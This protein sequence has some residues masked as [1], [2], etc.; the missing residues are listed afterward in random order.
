MSDVVLVSATGT[1]IGKTW[2]TCRLIEHARARSVPVAARKPV[3][4]FDIA[5]GPTDADLIGD[6]LGVDAAEVCPLHRWYE[7]P[8]APPM[9]AEALGLPPISLADL[10]AELTLPEIGMSFVEGVGGPRSPIADDAD[11]TDLAEALDPAAIVL[12]AHAGLGTINDV[13]LSVES[14]G[15]RDVAVFLNRFDRNNRLHLANAD[16]LGEAEGIE[17]STD[18]PSLFRRI[19]ATLTRSIPRQAD[20]MEVR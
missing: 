1:E 13:L 14:F 9:A 8:M 10:L 12:V 3:Q 16:W 15:G 4:S 11:T 19:S 6:A 5:D 2:V 20:E 18:I 17:V 7:L